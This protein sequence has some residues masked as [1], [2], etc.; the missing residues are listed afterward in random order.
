M[1][2]RALAL[3]LFSSSVVC[4]AETVLGVYMFHRHGDRTAKSTP[5]ANLTDLGYSEVY[6]SGQYY[7][8]RY[9]ASDASLKI[10]GLNSDVVL[11]SQI[12]VSAP[13]DTVL[14][15][16]AQGFLQ[17]LY[18]PVGSQLGNETLANGSGVEAPLNGYQLIPISLVS[19]GSGSEDS[20]W[21]QSSTGCGNSII[22]SN[23]YFTSTDYQ[24]LLKSTAGFYDNLTSAINDTFSSSQISYKNAYTIFDLINVAEIH[25]TSIHAFNDIL[26]PDVLLQI[27]TLADHHEFNLAYNTSEP[28]RAIAGATVAA[29]A[30][31]YLNGTIASN[32]NYSGPRLGIQFGAYNSFQSFFGLANLTGVDEDFYGIPDYASV[33]LF[34]LYTNASMPP[35]GLPSQDNLFVRFLFNNG[36]SANSTVP[37]M[38]PLFGGTAVDLRWTDFV[39]GMNKF[40]VGTT[41]Q[42]CQVCGNTTGTCAAYAST[43]GPTSSSE[44]SSGISAAVGGVIGAFVTLAVILGVEALILLLFGLRVVRKG[45]ISQSPESYGVTAAETKS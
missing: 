1:A 45:K 16:S 35:S 8:S 23:D 36:T 40:A 20:S 25:N 24:G 9:V 38:Y 2:L 31:Q 13:A 27:R 19:S 5:P 18:P 34:E 4:A 39:T 3:T 26:T 15:N 42:W 32:H 6:H 29:Q 17:G 12:A 7:R 33:M 21:L 28:A 43:P 22:S 44:R 14:Q 10:S 37:Q 41:Q 30:V 11:Q